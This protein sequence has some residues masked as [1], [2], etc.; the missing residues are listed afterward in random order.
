MLWLIVR[1]V[2]AVGAGLAGWFFAMVMGS[3]APNQVG[4]A[5]QAEGFG[6]L[7]AV[8][9]FIVMTLGWDALAWFGRHLR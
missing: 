7:V 6:A 2:S 1:L 4:A 8:A 3:F 5:K 9:V